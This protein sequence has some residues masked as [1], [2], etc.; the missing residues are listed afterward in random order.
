M[1]MASSAKNVSVSVQRELET[2]EKK[3]ASQ[4]KEAV[5]SKPAEDIRVSVQKELETFEKKFASQIKKA[6][7]TK[8]AD[9]SP[10]SSSEAAKSTNPQETKRNQL[11]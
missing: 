7:A 4:I 9:P 6:V 3:F 1:G 5:A 2:F 10:S 11:G 8:P